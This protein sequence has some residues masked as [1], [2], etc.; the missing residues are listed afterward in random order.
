VNVAGR[1]DPLPIGRF[2]RRLLLLSGLGWLF[3]SMD[4]GLVSFALAHLRTEWSLSTDQVA[5][6][7]GTPPVA[8]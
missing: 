8:P 6:A 5:L 2:H 7:I 3:D 1:L 4:T